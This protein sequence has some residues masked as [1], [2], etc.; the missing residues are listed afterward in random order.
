MVGTS[1]YEWAQRVTEYVQYVK[2]LMAS[3]RD[4]IR[5]YQEQLLQMRGDEV[6][7]VEMWYEEEVRKLKEKFKDLEDSPE[8]QQALRLL[9]E[10]YEE[11]LE[12]AKEAMEEEE[13]LWEDNEETAKEKSKS[14]GGAIS[15]NIIKNLKDAADMLR[16]FRGEMT[17]ETPE[18]FGAGE[19]GGGGIVP[20]NKWGEAI[21]RFREGIQQPFQEIKNVL[22][23]FELGINTDMQIRKEVK[24]DSF[25]QIQTFDIDTTRRWLKDTVFPEW[26]KYMKMKGVEF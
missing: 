3:L 13:N 7:L 14:M 5:S 8:Y 1:I 18:P 21:N 12:K 22:G 10:L 25:F 6:A 4:T 2:N 20:V 23:E 16:A 17:R 11:K 19:A 15:R 26:E 9:R 24:L